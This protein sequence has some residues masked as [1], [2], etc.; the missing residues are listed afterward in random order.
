MN[1]DLTEHVVTCP[2]CWEPHRLFIDTSAGST[3]YVEDCQVCCHPMD[4]TLSI[5]G[6]DVESVQ[7]DSA[8]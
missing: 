3:S 2:H 1:G 6:D 4:I 7:V 5:H 8:L